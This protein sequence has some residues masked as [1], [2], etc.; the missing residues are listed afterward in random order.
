MQSTEHS[1]CTAIVS[2]IGRTDSVNKTT[3]TAHLHDRQ[4]PW[5]I[6]NE[7][8][9]S[10]ATFF[11]RKSPVISSSSFVTLIFGMDSFLDDANM[12]CIK[13]LQSMRLLNETVVTQPQRNVAIKY[14]SVHTSALGDVAPR[15][16]GS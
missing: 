1:K 7:F 9:L 2:R 12:P 11:R 10:T 5:Q 6:N 13:P 4:W 15:V 16:T 3:K 14:K 8:T